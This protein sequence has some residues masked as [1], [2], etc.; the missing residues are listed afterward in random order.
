MIGRPVC[1]RSARLPSTEILFAVDN[2]DTSKLITMNQDGHFV[3]PNAFSSGRPAP[4]QS[5]ARFMST[6]LAE[7]ANKRSCRVGN[8]L[9]FK[10]HRPLM[11]HVLILI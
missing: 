11:D 6:F 10:E 2:T 3:R 9:S 4:S 1:R 7:N 8:T 5:V